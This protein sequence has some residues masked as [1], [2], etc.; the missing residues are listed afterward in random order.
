MDNASSKSPAGDW[1]GPHDQITLTAT[2][3]QRRAHDLYAHL[4]GLAAVDNEQ[5]AILR[6]IDEYLANVEASGLPADIAEN[7][8]DM[9]GDTGGALLAPGRDGFVL[10]RPDGSG[11]RFGV[12]TSDG[13]HRIMDFSELD[14]AEMAEALGDV[15]QDRLVEVLIELGVSRPDL[16]PAAGLV[17]TWAGLH[18]AAG[19]ELAAVFSDAIERGIVDA[20]ELQA[21]VDAAT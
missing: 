4:G 3:E 11:T 12:A 9:L 13:G 10:L 16:D 15:D 7:I 21:A 2:R 5:R 1:L 6:T 14:S 17:D 19:L 18:E 20:E 8:N